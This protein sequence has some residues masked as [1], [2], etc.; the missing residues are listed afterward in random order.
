MEKKMLIADDEKSVCENL[1]GFFKLRGFDVQTA[2]AGDEAL[3]KIKAVFFHIILL[4]IK[5]PGLSGTEVLKEAI[6]LHPESKII[7]VTGYHDEDNKKDC[8]QSGAYAYLDKPL[9]LA[10][11]CGIVD[12]LF[13]P[14]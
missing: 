12:R 9:D 4:D 8:L 1:G 3:D 11:L 6:K 13:K 2:Y 14:E 5:M 10:E 7:M